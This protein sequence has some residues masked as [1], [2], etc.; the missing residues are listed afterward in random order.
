MVPTVVIDALA[1]ARLSRLVAEDTFP[2]VA[3]ARDWYLRRFPVDNMEPDAPKGATVI[4][5]LDTG[6]LR[7]VLNG[8]PTRVVVTGID[9]DPNDASRMVMPFFT[10]GTE[11]GTLIECRFCNSFW[12]AVGV[13]AARRYVPRLWDPL[14]K[15]FAFSMVAALVAAH[16]S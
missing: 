6:T 1:V 3:R 4:E 10:E 5:E 7:G 15:A 14:A 12:L 8:W 2:P 9:R 13:V 16:E 11:L